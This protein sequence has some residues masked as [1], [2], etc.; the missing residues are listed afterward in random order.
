MAK[1]DEGRK[2]ELTP[3]RGE[4]YHP[5]D[6]FDELER[7][8]YDWGPSR[9]F[10]RS[11]HGWPLGRA[12]EPFRVR[13]PAVDVI[14]RED[15]VLVRAEVPGV[16]QDDLEVTV[17]E[18]SVTIS[19]HCKKEEEDKDKEGNYYRRETSYGEF[20]RTVG[21]P[22][23]VDADKGKAKFKDGLLEVTLPKVKATKRRGI[24][25]ESE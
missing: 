20:S 8:F 14:D 19:G 16:D 10:D 9:L 24:K 18:N 25:I 17:T 2:K 15:E 1:K 13:M 22:A 6:L 3:R 7:A 4:T 11:M 23:D 21:L 12:L 5:L